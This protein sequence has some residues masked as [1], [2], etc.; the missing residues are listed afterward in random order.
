MFTKNFFPRHIQACMTSTS[1]EMA[2]NMAISWPT[3]ISMHLLIIWPC[4]ACYKQCGLF[5]LGA[6][7]LAP[8]QDVLYTGHLLNIWNGLACYR[9]WHLART[10]SPNR[11]K[12][13]CTTSCKMATDMTIAWLIHTSV[14]LLTIWHHLAC[15]RLWGPLHF[16]GL[17]VTTKL[18]VGWSRQS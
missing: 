18:A 10:S 3:H 16:G 4:L 5:T 7:E 6:W 11:Y 17:G 8:R 13:Q 2:T 14:H 1:Y 12:H 15:Y 9:H